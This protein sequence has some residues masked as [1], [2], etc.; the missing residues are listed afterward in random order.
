M[1]PL[2][3]KAGTFKN[4]AGKREINGRPEVLKKTC[5]DALRRGELAL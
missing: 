5:E 1:N 4:D 3:S 2:A